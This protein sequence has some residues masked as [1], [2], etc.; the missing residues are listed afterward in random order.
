ME[1]A[2]GSKGKTL[3]C[4]DYIR[5]HYLWTVKFWGRLCKSGGCRDKLLIVEA[6]PL[7]DQ[8]ARHT[9]HS[10]PIVR[11]RKLQYYFITFSGCSRLQRLHEKARG[12]GCNSVLCALRDKLLFGSHK[13]N[14]PLGLQKLSLRHFW[15]VPRRSCEGG[16][17][18][19]CARSGFTSDLLRY[20]IL[21]ETCRLEEACTDHHDLCGR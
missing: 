18:T 15:D 14:E 16:E 2:R 3:T 19:V 20:T 1:G 7:T 8:T 10:A 17:N 12:Q 4:T 5:L 21:R 9:T 11:T 13:I 6:R